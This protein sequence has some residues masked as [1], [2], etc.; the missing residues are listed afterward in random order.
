M[1]LIE[2][3]SP[4]IHNISTSHQ[5]NLV[6]SRFLDEELGWISA[7]IVN[8]VKRGHYEIFIDDEDYS[9]S[10]PKTKV[11]TLKS[12]PGLDALPMQNED[13]PDEGVD[14]M[15]KLNFLH[16]ASI[17]DNL[18]RRFRSSL[19]YA[20]TGD[21]LIA[22]NPYHWL[23]IYTTELMDEYKE[24]LRQQ[25]PPH[26]YATSAAAYRGLR[27]FGKNQ[28]ILVSGESGAGKTETVK[29]LMGHL[30]QISGKKT[31][32]T[33]YRVLK[34]NPLMESFGNAK[35]ARND[36]SSRFGKF[37]QLQFDELTF[38]KGSR[39]V[40]YLLEKTRVVTVNENERSYHIFY[41]LLAAPPRTKAALKLSNK[42][43]M[44]F[45]YVNRGDVQT[46]AIEGVFDSDGFAKTM[47][48]LALVGI[49]NTLQLDLL[50]ILSGILHLGQIQFSGDSEQSTVDKVNSTLSTS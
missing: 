47:E 27:D 12:F 40:T 36:N 39:C 4:T 42:S 28:S 29:I 11:I 9:D 10:L 22:T 23:D 37:T 6:F 1:L 18:R 50:R 19:P 49:D 15:A 43:C 8:E 30:A 17:L 46:K 44:D 24:F 14:D 33:V 38:L 25:L 48:I 20:Y 35:T 45:M 7:E 21:I 26:A 31:D 3:V 2:I 32:E 34:A 41:Q 13:I 16:E 5:L